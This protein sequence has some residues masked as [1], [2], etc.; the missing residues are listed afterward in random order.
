MFNFEMYYLFLGR[1]CLV[2]TI[3]INELRDPL[4]GPS[5]EQIASMRKF[6]CSKCPSAFRTKQSL[7]RHIKFECGQDPHYMCPYCNRLTKKSSNAYTHVRRQHPDQ[8]VYI[9]D[10]RSGEDAKVV[11]LPKLSKGSESK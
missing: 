3:F 6:A 2:E 8:K 7:S 9:I 5:E 10:L 1:S 11:R 4:A